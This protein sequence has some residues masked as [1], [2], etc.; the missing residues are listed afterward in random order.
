MISEDLVGRLASLIVGM[1][2]TFL[3]LYFTYRKN[4]AKIE[5]EGQKS[6]QAVLD[7]RIDRMFAHFQRLLE[8]E[9]KACTLKIQRLE[10]EVARLSDALSSYQRPPQR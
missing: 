4:H 9:Q 8:E 10:A 5:S 1:M 6:L 2:G 7:D 3:T